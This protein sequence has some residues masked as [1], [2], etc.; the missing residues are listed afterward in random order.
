MNNYYLSAIHYDIHLDMKLGYAKSR[1]FQE[2]SL[3]ELE[4]LQHFY[5]LERTQFL[6]SLAL[7]LLKR[8]YARYLLSDIRS[9]FIGYEGNILWYCTCTKNITIL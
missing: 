1:I 7:A 5:E 2:I 8:P 9:K 4:T 6:Q 3:S